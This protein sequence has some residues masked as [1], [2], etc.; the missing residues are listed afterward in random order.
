MP[1]IEGQ[2]M[3][4]GNKTPMIRPTAAAARQNQKKQTSSIL[5][6]MVDGREFESISGYSITNMNIVS[7]IRRAI[8]EIEQ[9]RGKKLICYCANVVNPRI[10][11]ST[12]IDFDDN[13]PFSELVNTLQTNEKDVDVVIITNGGSAQQVDKFVTKL[14]H[15]FDKVSFILPSV[16][17]SAGTIFIMSGNE[18]IMTEDSVFGPIDPQI[19]NKEGRYVPAQAILTLLNTI[20]LRGEENIKNHLPPMWS[21]LEILRNLDH[22]DLGAAMTASA[23]CIQLVTNY[24]T[25]YKF[26]T[27]VTHSNGVPVTQKEKED[28]AEEIAG[29]LCDHATWKSHASAINRDTAETKCMLEI[30]HAEQI[31]GLDRAIRRFNV[32]FHWLFENTAIAKAYISDDYCIIRSDK[33]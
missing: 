2:C 12:S 3:G 22:K 18:I 7:E 11:T 1:F 14:R 27:W 25:N 28:R 15:R 32:L 16:A 29:L 21:D 33:I 23:Y 5:D 31:T 8:S 4:K 20:Q 10:K 13:L 17:M 24:L 9:I 19:P 30:V 6:V 26:S